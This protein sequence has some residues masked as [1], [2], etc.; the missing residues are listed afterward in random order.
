MSV[1]NI[2]NACNKSLSVVMW[3]YHIIFSINLLFFCANSSVY[4]RLSLFFR[5]QCVIYSRNIEK[6][7]QKQNSTVIANFKPLKRTQSFQYWALLCA[8]FYLVIYFKGKLWFT[9]IY[10][11]M[12][13]LLKTFWT[14]TF[15][16]T[17]FPLWVL[18]R[19]WILAFLVSPL[20]IPQTK[21]VFYF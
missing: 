7:K 10:F 18:P 14:S 1:L 21:C 6:Q 4:L 13:I 9:G 19:N 5:Y 8:T 12:S 15:M 20:L 16:L 3:T 2:S 17:S 11:L